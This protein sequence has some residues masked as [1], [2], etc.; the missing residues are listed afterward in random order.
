MP[1]PSKKEQLEAL[2]REHA[3]ERA[4][5]RDNE[6]YVREG[7]DFTM[8]MLREKMARVLNDSELDTEARK[9][10][11]ALHKEEIEQI[12][13]ARAEREHEFIE[14]ELRNH[15][16]EQELEAEILAEEAPPPPAGEG[17]NIKFQSRSAL[18]AGAELLR[19]DIQE[20]S[21]EL[22]EEEQFSTILI[23]SSERGHI[24]TFVRQRRKKQE[25]A[26]P[27]RIDTIVSKQREIGMMYK[28]SLEQQKAQ[29]TSIEDKLKKSQEDYTPP[30]V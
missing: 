24:P 16:L 8:Q 29:L 2:K 21:K 22:S 13:D 23:N 6:M 10:K 4:E 3:R 11:L 15:Q 9:E 1:N 12:L 7:E 5:A 26:E 20:K 14:R 30:E 25:P 19:K 17:L 27:V 28:E 18:T